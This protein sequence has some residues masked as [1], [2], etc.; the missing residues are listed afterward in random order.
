MCLFLNKGMIYALGTRY[1]DIIHGL[2]GDLQGV[3]I[4]Y[5]PRIHHI[6]LFS[7]QGSG[8]MLIFRYYGLMHAYFL[9]TRHEDIISKILFMVLMGI[10]RELKYCIHPEYIICAYSR[11]MVLDI[12]LFLDL[13]FNKGLMHAYFLGT[14]Y[15][16]II[17]NVFFKYSYLDIN[18]FQLLF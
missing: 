14:R 1:Q 6:C 10:Y 15:E 13:Y 4:L 9:G 8:Y 7:E 12:C 17:S 5:S 16:D 2:N 11:N 18:N 3:E